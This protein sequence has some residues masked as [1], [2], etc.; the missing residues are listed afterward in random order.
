VSLTTLV[1][2][3]VLLVLGRLI[4][5]IH[6]GAFLPVTLVLV[7]TVL[8]ASAF[9]IFINSLLKSTKQGGVVFGGVLTLTGMLGMIR[10]FTMGSGVGSKL[11]DSVGLLVPQGWAVRGLFQTMGAASLPNILLTLAALVAMSIVFFVIGVLRFQKRY[12]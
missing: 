10:V 2:M 8:A 1:Q 5:G 7:G 3:S 12:A 11:G 6:W 9:G 4:F